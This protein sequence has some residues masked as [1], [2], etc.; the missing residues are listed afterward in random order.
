MA[1]LLAS[2]LIC[3]LALGG[4]VVAAQERARNCTE[5]LLDMQSF[6][7]DSKTNLIN[8]HAP[9]ITQCAMTIIADQSVATSTDFQ[10][11]SE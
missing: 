4:S 1:N 8:L 7:L 6:E 2:L 11:K 10:A 5:V 9:R 3:V